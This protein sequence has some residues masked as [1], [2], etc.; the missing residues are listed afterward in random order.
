V[1]TCVGCGAR[2]LQTSLI[3]LT[4]AGQDLRIDAVGHGRG[5]YLHRDSACWEGFLRK[6]SLFRALRTEISRSSRQKLLQQL[7]ELNRE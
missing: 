6:K 3:R 2:D 4:A 5:A 1:R 7:G